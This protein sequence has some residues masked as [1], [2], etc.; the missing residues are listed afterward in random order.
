MIKCSMSLLDYSAKICLTA[1]GVLVQQN[2]ALLIKHKKLGLWLNPGGH[3][4]VDE[5]PHITAEREFKEE[6]G[7]QVRAILQGPL[8]SDTDKG[9]YLP[10]PFATN[11]H[12]VCEDNFQRRMSNPTEYQP[13]PQWKRGCEQHL[14]FVYL[15]KLVG[16]E[17]YTRNVQETDDIRWFT[18]E[19]LA[20]ADI[21]PS[22][23]Q[24]VTAAFELAAIT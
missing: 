8:A 17:Q 10:H 6:T 1:S 20:T 2:R 11:L 3:I 7:L 18:P 21:I 9:E 24:E 4:E 14:N 5:A 13:A 22:I 16:S 19:E 15:M 12:W 23:V